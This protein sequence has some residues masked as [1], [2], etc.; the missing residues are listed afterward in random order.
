[1][2]RVSKIIHMNNYVVLKKILQSEA[3]HGWVNYAFNNFVF[4]F[5]GFGGHF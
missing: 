4:S 3:S 2:L 5:H 1:M